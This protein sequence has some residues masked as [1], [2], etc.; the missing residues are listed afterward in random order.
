M[1]TSAESE[2]R[3]QTLLEAALKLDPAERAAFIERATTDAPSLGQ[4]VKSRLAAR[5]AADHPASQ[6]A[7][8]NAGGLTA[9]IGQV[10]GHYK[11]L[12]FLGRG[13]VGEVYLAQDSRLGRKVPLKVLPTSLSH[14]EDRLRRFEREARSAST[15]NHPN[16]CVIYEVGETEDGHPFIAMEH[17]VGRTLR[18]RFA[19]GSLRLDTAIDITLQVASALAAAHQ[20]GVVHRDIK[21]E[22]VMLRD[23]GYV[24][25]LD[26]GL[27]KLTERYELGADSEAQTLLAFNTHS[28]V[29]VGTPNYV[30]PEQARHH[31]VDERTDI[32]SLGVMLYE[33]VA[34]RMPFMGET[35]SHTIV[36]ILEREPAPV[37]EVV[38]DLP[39][40]LEW[41][42]KKALRKD[43]E[44]R[45]Q[46]IKGLIGDLKDLKKKIQEA[47][48]AP[49]PLAS[50]IQP[51]TTH[52]STLESI[53][54]TLR[55]PRISIGF[56]VI[57][58]VLLASVTWA[59]LHWSK[60]PARPFQNMHLI[61]LTNTGNGVFNGSA[62]SPDGK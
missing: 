20:A 3:I 50:K 53:S 39:A 28:G 7:A 22:N 12:A 35:P 47:S 26:F 9:Q 43:R 25:V 19:E 55:Q 42:I 48:E 23:D 15:L 62:I 59:L 13:G 4:E 11:M 49:P 54:Q 16:V 29:M 38:A 14:D 2:R 46:T 1:A 6:A 45:Y 34:G 24:K 57:A 18:Q 33:M 51:V 36:A 17:I 61:K 21:P 60:P 37:T 32:W 58:L 31:P 52:P 27:A 40:E 5:A 8:D 56:F 44:Q 30:S 41:I 10:V